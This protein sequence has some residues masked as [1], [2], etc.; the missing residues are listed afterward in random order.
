MQHKSLLQSGCFKCLPWKG[1]LF[2][3]FFLFLFFFFFFFFFVVVVFLHENTVKRV[4]VFNISR[5]LF[6]VSFALFQA[7]VPS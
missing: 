5:T 7:S 6:R 3:V 4:S 2:I 1:V